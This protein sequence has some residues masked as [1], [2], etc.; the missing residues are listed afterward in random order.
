[1][2]KLNRYTVSFIFTPDLDSVWLIEKK[3]PEWQKGCYNGIGGKIE[4]G[5]N[6]LEAAKREIFEESG[7]FPENL[8]KVGELVGINMDEEKFCVTIFTT[9]TDKILETK[10]LETIC[11]VH[12]SNLIY[13]NLIDNIKLLLE[14]SLLKIKQPKMNS[15]TISY[16]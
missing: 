5:E 9:I 15:I 12:L 11:L 4:K 7:F 8:T 1:M 3:K 10:E 2:K 16:K 13:L 6:T 14:A